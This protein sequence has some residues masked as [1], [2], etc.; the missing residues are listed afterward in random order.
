MSPGKCP[1]RAA[2]QADGGAAALRPF[3]PRALVV[4]LLLVVG[5]EDAGQTVVQE[6]VEQIVAGG[7]DRE[8][9][10]T[11]V[12]GVGEGRQIPQTAA[13]HRCVLDQPFR[14]H[15][16]DVEATLG[17]GDVVEHAVYVVAA[18]RAQLDQHGGSVHRQP[19]RRAGRLRL[20]QL[21]GVEQHDRCHGQRLVGRGGG[22]AAIGGG[23]RFDGLDHAVK[24]PT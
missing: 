16:L 18:A 13:P 21:A 19:Q 8:V 11:K 4:D 7:A 24:S 6:F 10:G 20:V 3:R 17:C 15:D 22:D 9:E 2:R 14:H 12:P 5:H 1:F 23:G